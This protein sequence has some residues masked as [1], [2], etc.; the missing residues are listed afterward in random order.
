LTAH[1]VLSLEH[2]PPRYSETG[3]FWNKDLRTA[4]AAQGN[5]RVRLPLVETMFELL[6][7]VFTLSGVL[8]AVVV[9]AAIVVVAVIWRYRKLD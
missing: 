8:I 6:H 2:C 4:E 3:F 5:D 1:V 7:G 9:I